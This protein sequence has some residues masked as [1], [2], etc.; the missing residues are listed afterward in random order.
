MV[1]LDRIVLAAGGLL[2]RATLGVLG[3]TVLIGWYAPPPEP[4]ATAPSRP[5]DPEGTAMTVTLRVPE[6]ANAK[7]L[8]VVNA[9]GRELALLTHWI[10]GMTTVVSG[11]N[12]GAGVSYHLND[13]GSANL[14]VDGTA[15]VTLIRADKDGTTRVS[16]RAA[17]PGA[18]P[19]T[20][21]DT[22]TPTGSD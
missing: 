16:N 15:W 22:G 11:R 1:R 4:A 12:G 17:L 21:M 18:K 13:D 2:A 19:R 9:S 8:T 20:M 3:L 10:T 14:R 6:G 7:H 5:D